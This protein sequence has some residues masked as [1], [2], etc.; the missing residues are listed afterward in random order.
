MTESTMLLSS[1]TYCLKL[2]SHAVPQTTAYAIWCW[3]VWTE[4]RIWSFL[5]KIHKK[6]TQRTF[7]SW[8][9]N[10]QCPRCCAIGHKSI[11]SS[12]VM[13]LASPKDCTSLPNRPSFWEFNLSVR[14]YREIILSPHYLSD[15]QFN[16]LLVLA[17]TSLTL[18]AALLGF[19]FCCVS[20]T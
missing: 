3:L 20:F 12:A 5:A 8:H 17:C 18:P 16:S 13:W 4:Y 19:F 7:P 2:Y 1:S 14:Y 15:I 10:F 6:E 11:S 9:A